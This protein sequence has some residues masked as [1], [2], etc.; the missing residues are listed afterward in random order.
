[1]VVGGMVVVVVGG[2]VF[3]I[4]ETIPLVDRGNIV[5]VC[6]TVAALGMVVAVDMGFVDMAAADMIVVVIAT[7]GG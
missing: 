3:D 5:G 4:G 7:L 1:M 6:E 2:L